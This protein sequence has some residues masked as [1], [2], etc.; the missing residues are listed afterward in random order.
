MGKVVM[1]KNSAVP[2]EIK[3]AL[4]IYYDANDWLKNDEF[5]QE[6]KNIIGGDQYH[7]SYTKKVQMLSYFGFTTWEDFSKAQSRR[8]ITNSGK[9][10]YEAW[11]VNNKEALLEEL[12]YSLEHTIFG[13]NNC[14]AS[15]SDSDVEIPSV[16]IRTVLELGYLTYSE[17]AYLLWQMEDCGKNYTDAVNELRKARNQDN[18]ALTEEAKK[19]T[20]AK[21][22]MMLIRWGF[23]AEDGKIGASTKIIVSKDVLSKFSKRLHNLKIYNVDKELDINEIEI[24]PDEQKSRFCVWMSSQKKSNGE[25]YSKNTINNYITNMSLGYKKFNK[26]KNYDSVFEI[27]DNNELN[28][29]T[30]HLFNE[31]G[32]D[33]FNEGNGRR[34]CSNAFTKYSEFL[35]ESS[36]ASNV[37]FETK[38]ENK[39]LKI[40]FKTGFES[41]FYRNRI[42]FGAPG[43][44][45]SFTLNK[46]RKELLGE[47]NDIDY[48]RVTFHPDYSYANFVGTYKPVPCKDSDDKDAI[49]YEY[50]PGPFMRI[51]V[52]A[53]KNGRTDDVKPFLLIVE[54]I[55]RAN[56][57]AAFGEIFQL[58]DRDDDE[59]SEYPIQASED[60]K[61]YL[62]RELG[63]EPEQY[64]KIKIPD[65]MFI[66]ATMNSAD[67]GV[68]PMDTAFK[69]RWDFT[70]LGIDD[71]ESGI[72]GKGVSIGE[73]ANQRN[74]EWNELRK[75]IN[76]RLAALKVNEDKLLGPY[77][78]SK[79]AIFTGDEIDS[80]KFKITFKNKVIMYL[81][82]DA[83]KQKK[84]SLFAEGVD[85]TKYSSVCKAFEEKG[86]FVFCAEISNKFPATI[87]SESAE[88]NAE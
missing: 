79:K 18:L 61:K 72:V 60:I 84:S 24:N 66:W 58:L 19:Y 25:L 49:T 85:T 5:I 62:A 50:V 28:E 36:E 33:E 44:G 32:F 83:A 10:F 4:K 13:R 41:K 59:V 31:T 6:L 65:N 42:L 52:E 34:A 88:E 74:A 43:T 38:L 45:K 54:E 53:L 17:F 30:K 64:S 69:R 75:A 35:R 82:E 51:Y 48:E 22:I 26:H 55:N 29:Y 77:F 80:Q 27:Q 37:N 3:A 2:E 76:D 56:V 11:K 71:S 16:F 86:I 23:L 47:N 20:D 81:F 87:T 78:L 73:G 1:P 7:S 12:M 8:K 63:G 68:F 57:A 14:G 21:P 70:Y 67:Q 9:R 39:Q 40:R 46:E 15:D